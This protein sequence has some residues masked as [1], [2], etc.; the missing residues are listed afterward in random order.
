MYPDYVICIERLQCLTFA[1]LDIWGRATPVQYPLPPFMKRVAFQLFR[2]L[3]VLLNVISL[4]RVSSVV[5]YLCSRFSPCGLIPVWRFSTG[6]LDAR[7]WAGVTAVT[8]NS[9]MLRLLY[10]NSPILSSHPFGSSGD[11]QRFVR[12]A[13]LSRSVARS[14]LRLRSGPGLSRGGYI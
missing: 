11:H 12:V 8:S 2:V 4:Y 10:Q 13:R 14:F 7:R 5:G 3:S 6:W 1:F 9:L